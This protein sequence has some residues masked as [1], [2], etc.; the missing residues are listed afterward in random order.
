MQ[1]TAEQTDPC[2]LVLDVNIDEQ[3]VAR[4][5]DSSYREFGRYA[6]VP[7]FRPGKA[8]RAI[9]E[10]FVDNER[11]RQHA[12][13]KI[14]RE[15][16]P[17][18][19]EEQGVEP[20]REPHFDPTDLEDKKPFT[21]KATI[22]LQPQV[23]IREYTGLTVEKPLFAVTDKMVDRQIEKL[24]DERARLERVSDRAVELG[25]ILIAETQV[26]LE[27]ESEPAAPRRQLV[28]MGNNIPGYDEALVGM[29][30]GDEKHFDL[31]YPDDYQDEDRRGKSA[32]FYVKLSS[33]SARRLPDLD[34]EFVK[35]VAGSESVAAFKEMVRERLQ[36]DASRIS[37]EITE[38]RII[39]KIL[40]KADI[41]FPQI[42]VREE[43][44][45][46]LRQLSI[47]LK[48][49]NASYS[50][51]LSRLGVS[52]EEHQTGLFEEAEGQIR[53]LL[54][55]REVAKQELLQAEEGAIDAEFARLAEEGAISAERYEEFST[56]PRRRMQV[57]N[58]LIQQKLHDFLFNN[59][60]LV[61]V[62]Q[63][64][65]ATENENE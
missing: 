49:N 29:Q 7:G 14:I 12:L 45:E 62:E 23:T 48:Q 24:R 42:L 35:D 31:T 6:N 33:I 51:Y 65:E 17:Q 3:Q 28:Q 22:P 15:T 58:A 55:L 36:A 20:Y 26:V 16:Y 39:E 30:V 38:Q 50:D 59:N 57:A 27:G 9:V 5:F 47:D 21:Y 46:K 43:V 2:T 44:E 19:I 61:E 64:G 60:T 4:A 52:Q 34:D 8:P 53:S 10:R 13:E 18:V 40:E 37:N 25:D 1:V 41:H 11:V 63:K 56:D 54:A 32:Q